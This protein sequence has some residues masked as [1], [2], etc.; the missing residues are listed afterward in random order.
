LT[1]ELKCEI[2]IIRGKDLKLEANGKI[3]YEFAYVNGSRAGT[4]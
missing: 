1:G 4:M 2:R 3:E